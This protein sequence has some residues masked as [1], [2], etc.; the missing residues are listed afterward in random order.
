MPARRRATGSIEVICGS[1]FSG[2]TEELLRRLR[3][4]EIA[5]Q[6]VQVFKHAV[7]RRYSS[8]HVQSHDATRLPSRSVKDGA[9]ILKLV[10]RG[11]KV[12]GIDEAQFFGPELIEVASLLA[13]RGVRVI[14]AGLDTDYLARPF[15]PMPVLLSIA[16]EVTKLRAICARCGATASR[17]QRTHEVRGREGRQVAVGA[18]EAYEARCR[19]CYRAPR[20]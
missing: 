4:A 14:V 11:T 15:G 20:G 19:A 1:M 10:R 2:K 16:E 3:R 17:T 12:V 18:R 5:R 13:E 7:D 9:Q 6:K 8:R